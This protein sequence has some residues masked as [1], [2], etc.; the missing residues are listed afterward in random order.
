MA[1]DTT[2]HTE[3][4]RTYIVTPRRLFQLEEVH[5]YRLKVPTFAGIEDIEQFIAEF[6][7]TWAITQWPLRVV[8]AKLRGALTG[9]AKPYGQRPRIDGTFV[10][11]RDRFGTTALDAGF[12]LQR[13]LRKK[14]TSFQDHALA[15]KRLAQIAYSD[16]PGTQGQRYMLEDFT[17]S[18]NH[19]SLHHQL[20][21]KRV[22]SIEAA[23]QEGEAYL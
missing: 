21:A 11:L 2:L 7:K 8:L 18:I 10:A 13:L 4:E 17:Q 14:D 12:R 22:T 16:L 23:L 3:G 1:E 19:P 9:E 5:K 20:E 15:V 6:N